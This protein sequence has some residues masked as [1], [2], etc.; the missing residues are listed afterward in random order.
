MNKSAEFDFSYEM[1]MYINVL[2]INVKFRV[3]NQ[4]YSFLIIY[5]NC[6]CLK[7]L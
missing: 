3:L 5:L 7:S 4:D 1:M 2:H 6:N